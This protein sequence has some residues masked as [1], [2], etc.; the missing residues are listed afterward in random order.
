LFLL[1]MGKSFVLCF[2]YLKVK[3]G[4]R[5]SA[6]ASASPR[7][8]GGLSIMGGGGGGVEEKGEEVVL[9]ANRGFVSGMLW[10]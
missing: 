9:L 2:S 6:S 5:A 8:W 10:R 7:L 4:G 3:P 1:R